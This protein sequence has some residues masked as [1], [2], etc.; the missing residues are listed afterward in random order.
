MSLPKSGILTT[1]GDFKIRLEQLWKS[2]FDQ[3]LSS[4]HI[5]AATS[6]LVAAQNIKKTK[7]KQHFCQMQS[8]W[9][10]NGGRSSFFARGEK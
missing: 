3:V 2:V 1:R 8:C 5:Q 10:M 4:Q 7:K 6:L 9:D